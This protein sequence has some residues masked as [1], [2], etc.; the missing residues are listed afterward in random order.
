MLQLS[1]KGDLP[2]CHFMYDLW[3]A[4]CDLAFLQGTVHVLD[5]KWEAKTHNPLSC[6]IFSFGRSK[7]YLLAGNYFQNPR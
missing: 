3:L 1:L 5:F 7:H 6:D 2:P 4:M